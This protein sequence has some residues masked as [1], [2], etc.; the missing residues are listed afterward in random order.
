MAAGRT[1]QQA[2][3]GSVEGAQSISK[4]ITLSGGGIC[5]APTHSA[6]I[7]ACSHLPV[8]LVDPLCFELDCGMSTYVRA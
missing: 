3:G 8:M 1:A 2:E 5:E 6:R 7:P 4:Q